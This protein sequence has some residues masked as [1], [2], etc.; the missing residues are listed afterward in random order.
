MIDSI[1]RLLPRPDTLLTDFIA[2]LPL[3]VCL[4]R[5]QSR[6]GMFFEIKTTVEIKEVSADEYTFWMHT[7]RSRDDALVLKFDGVLKRQDETTTQVL[8]MRDYERLDYLGQVL[9]MVALIGFVAGLLIQSILFAILLAAGFAWGLY[10]LSDHSLRT[11]NKQIVT[12]VEQIFGAH[13]P[14]DKAK[15]EAV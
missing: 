4:D 7:T 15:R 3:D 12:S 5:L 10:A 8:I 11:T 1:N 6:D 2:P 13:T 14:D 9:V